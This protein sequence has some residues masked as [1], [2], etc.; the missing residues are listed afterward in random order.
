MFANLSQGNFSGA[1]FKEANLKG[2]NFKDAYLS[3]ANFKGANVDL[4]EL[5]KGYLVDAVMPNGK[6]FSA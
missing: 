6:V 4:E 3:G 5:K 2:V 1:N